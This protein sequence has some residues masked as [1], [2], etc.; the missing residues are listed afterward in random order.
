[1]EQPKQHQQKQIQVKQHSGNVINP[2]LD[3]MSL[4]SLMEVQSLHEQKGNHFSQSVLVRRAI[5][6]YNSYLKQLGNWEHE[7][8]E[9]KRAAKGVL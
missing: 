7:E 2:N 5:R 9:T 4:L 8:V 6:I 3:D 1:M